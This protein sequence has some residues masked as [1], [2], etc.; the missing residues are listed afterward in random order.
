MSTQFQVISDHRRR[1]RSGAVTMFS[2]AQYCVVV[3]YVQFVNHVLTKVITS[4]ILSF[5]LDYISLSIG[6]WG[7][8]EDSRGLPPVSFGEHL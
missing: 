7:V 3:S 1:S 5:V 8:V 2:E 6:Q 4:S